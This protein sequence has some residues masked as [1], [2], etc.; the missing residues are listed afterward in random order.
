MLQKKIP[1]EGKAKLRGLFKI[2]EVDKG[3]RKVRS[4]RA[5]LKKNRRKGKTLSKARNER[6]VG[7]TEMTGLQKV[8]TVVS[9]LSQTMPTGWEWF[10]ANYCRYSPEVGSEQDGFSG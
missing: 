7:I 1:F 3:C 2:R 10:S 4:K 6:T 8:P 9:Q 5:N